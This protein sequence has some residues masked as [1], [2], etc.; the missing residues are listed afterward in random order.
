[1]TTRTLPHHPLH[2]WLPLHP[3]PHLALPL[4]SSSNHPALLVSSAPSVIRTGT[5]QW[6]PKHPCRGKGSQL[7]DGLPAA[8]TMKGPRSPRSGGKL[9]ASRVSSAGSAR[10]HAGNRPKEVWTQRASEFLFPLSASI[11][12]IPFFFS[13]R[14]SDSFFPVSSQ[15]RSRGMDCEFPTESRRGARRASGSATSQKHAH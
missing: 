12:S 5:L 11:S 9:S 10:S 8:Q 7:S 6:N 1:M 4:P 3:H 15:C 13:F 2:T 14:K